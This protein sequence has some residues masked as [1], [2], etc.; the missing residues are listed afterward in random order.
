M[1]SAE[2]TCMWIE[3]E[4]MRDDTRVRVRARGSREE[5]P[6][7][8]WLDQTLPGELQRFAVGV[9]EAA[10]RGRPLGAF[11]ASSREIH[12]AL[13]RAGVANLRARMAATS[14]DQ[15]LLLRLAITD[16]E[17]QTIPWEALCEPGSDMGFLASA[18]DVLP[19][20]GV[21]TND[22]WQPRDVP[23]AIKV[24][25]IAP[26]GGASLARI[27]DVLREHMTSGT[28]EWLPPIVGYA[29]SPRLLFDR[30]R[31]DRPNVVHFLGHGRVRDGI[32]ELQ[33]AGEHSEEAWLSVEL[34]GQQLAAAFKSDLRLVVLE[35]CEGAR[36]GTFASAAEIL[37]KAGA[38][39][40][41]AHLWPVRFDVARRCSEHFYAA[42]ASRDSP[43]CGDVARSLNEA[44]RAVLAAFEGSAEAFS[45]VLYLRARQGKLFELHARRAGMHE[46]QR[47]LPLRGN[48]PFRSA[49]VW[50]ALLG[51]V[52][53]AI[54]GWS[55]GPRV[56]STAARAARTVHAI[57]R[58]RSSAL[59]MPGIPFVHACSEKGST[60]YTSRWRARR[61][62]SRAR[63]HEE[64][65]RTW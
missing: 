9:R 61:R 15:P 2:A 65:R 16:V 44:R 13:F 46:K 58:S 54:A 39:A 53:V 34:F 36:P 28:I 51:L 43:S 59:V 12:G 6:A 27:E 48:T 7:P 21:A 60:L 45:P 41:I 3:I 63:L 1:L 52:L 38:D 30:L 47:D 50:L 14:G 49:N 64:G 19:T 5:H 62:T 56:F 26:E 33:L 25:A 24:L 10:L 31:T 35:A 22:P 55:I 32:P 18:P 40:V 37:A 42:L 23:G 29:A 17:L 4:L 8:H 57:R 20:R 11:L